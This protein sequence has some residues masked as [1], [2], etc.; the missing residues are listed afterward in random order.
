MLSF[1]FSLLLVYF[2]SKNIFICWQ[3]WWKSYDRENSAKTEAWEFSG[4]LPQSLILKL[5]WKY[6]WHVPVV[7]LVKYGQISVL[8]IHSWVEP[9]SNFRSFLLQLGRTKVFLRAGQIG[10]LDSRRA[11]ILDNAAKCVQRQFRTFIARRDF[12]STRAAASALQACC[13]GSVYF[14]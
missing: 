1:H 13:R 4:G 2:P 7:H 3:L 11:E 6:S 12:L 5:F 10:I 8:F 9:K 14:L